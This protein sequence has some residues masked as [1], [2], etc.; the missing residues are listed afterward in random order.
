MGDRNSHPNPKG[1]EK[2]MI[3]TIIKTNEDGKPTLSVDFSS[4]LFFHEMFLVKG[5]KK[6]QLQKLVEERN[7]PELFSFLLREIGAEIFYFRPEDKSLGMRLLEEV[8][9]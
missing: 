8:I 2:K 3:N 1:E 9:Q 7:L 6:D 4:T 5:Q